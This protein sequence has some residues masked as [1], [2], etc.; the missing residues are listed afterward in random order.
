MSNNTITI[1]GNINNSFI[2]QN[3][4][5][6]TQTINANNNIDYEKIYNTMATIKDLTNSELFCKEFKTQSKEITILIDKAII[7]SKNQEN[8][9]ELNS[10]INKIKSFCLNVGTGVISS[11]I[12]SLLSNL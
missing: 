6:S 1:R 8:T 11:G 3:A 2:Q 5:N 10:I 4:N 7:L 9:N 12:Y